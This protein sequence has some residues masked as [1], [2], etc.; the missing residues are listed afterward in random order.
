MDYAEI[1]IPV[2]VSTIS[3]L[4][5][6]F[7]SCENVQKEEL[8]EKLEVILK[9]DPD[10]IVLQGLSAMNCDCIFRFL[11]SNK[12]KYTRFDAAGKNKYF[13]VFATKNIVLEGGYTQF[14]KTSQNKGIGKCLVG[15]GNQ[16]PKK[17]WIFTGCFDSSSVVN[18]KIQ[19][20]ELASEAKKHEGFPIIF[21]GNTNIPVWQDLK[22][23]K[24]WSD[25]WKTKGASNNEKT[26][27][28][29]RYDRM[30]FTG[31][32]NVEKFEIVDFNGP[33]DERKG[34]FSIFKSV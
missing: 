31:N 8:I 10:V 9:F 34:I 28:Q 24:D 14:I 27:L 13:E 15:F 1:D 29:D 5:F 6:D 2:P 20:A 7:S 26:S 3:I 33:E 4:S 22:E 32:V 11:K 19:V 21:A 23:P 16:N 17:V 25:A 12:Y 18:R 30:W